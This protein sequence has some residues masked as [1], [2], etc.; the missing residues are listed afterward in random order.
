MRLRLAYKLFNF[1][2]F[3]TGSISDGE[4]TTE[5]FRQPDDEIPTSARPTITVSVKP[6]EHP[7][8]GNSID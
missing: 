4:E 6:P 5:I 7:I 2:K 1:F 3:P 8:G